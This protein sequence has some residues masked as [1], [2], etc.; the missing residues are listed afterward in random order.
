MSVNNITSS[1]FASV[2]AETLKLKRTIILWISLAG[3][4]F[5]AVLLFSAYY[6][7][8]ERFVP[9]PNTNPWTSYMT[10]SFTNISIFSLPLFIVILTSAMA[11][12]EHGSNTW[13]FLYVLPIPKWN[14][15]F[16]KLAVILML[17]AITYLT[18]LVTTLGCGYLLGT[19][20]PDLE[21]NQYSPN[22]LSILSIVCHSFIAALAF[23]GLQYWLSIRWKSY[24][25]PVSI[26]LMGMIT[27]I[28]VTGKTKAALFFPYAFPHF[29]SIY[30][31]FGEPNRFGVG[32][33]GALT[34]VEWLSIAF[35]TA[36]V[37]IGYYEE[38]RSNIK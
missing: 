18:F 20:R 10:L 22:V 23:V 30:F 32:M 28:I 38:S 33:M 12:I 29:I 13:K 2:K 19:L 14:F 15:Y 17:L 26:G 4:V 31:R 6:F 34:N 8:W 1:F 24:I 27:A 3:G 36:F 9:M 37:A 21:F 7:E 35:F 16:A 11:N 25:V 5:I